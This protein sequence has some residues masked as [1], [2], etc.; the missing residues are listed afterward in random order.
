[1]AQFIYILLTNHDVR[2][3]IDT[4][5]SKTV[6]I[7][8]RFTPERK[9]IL[10]AIREALRERNYTPILFDFERPDSKTLTD[11]VKLLAQMSRFIIVD[12]SDPSSSPLEVGII[13][14]ANLKTTPLAPSITKG[15]HV[16]AM[17]DDIL[18]E[19]WCL[20]IHEYEDQE[21]LLQTLEQ[22]VIIPAES[23][24]KQLRNIINRTR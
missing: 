7:L 11:T 15:K 9:S 14:Q 16:F 8:G 21:H 22:S 17:F 3:I 1:M 20:D 19:K 5:T 10:D 13:A 18:L 4:L 12:L 6:L 24:V 2:D 23:K